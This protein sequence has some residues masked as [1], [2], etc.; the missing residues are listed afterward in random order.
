MAEPTCDTKGQDDTADLALSQTVDI[1]HLRQGRSKRR[2]KLALEDL[3][4]ARSKWDISQ[5]YSAP[6]KLFWRRINAWSTVFPVML[7]NA[8][9]NN[10]LV[11]FTN[12]SDAIDTLADLEGKITADISRA[13]AIH[14]DFIQC[15]NRETDLSLSDLLM[16]NEQ[17]SHFTFD[18]SVVEAWHVSITLAEYLLDLLM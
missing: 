9:P 6:S 11:L 4:Q 13:I 2:S 16:W 8:V 5:Y 14:R 12:P 18:L 17:M 15:Q 10:R 1:T 7:S 3:L